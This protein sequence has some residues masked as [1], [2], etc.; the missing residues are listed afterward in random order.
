[1]Q[2]PAWQTVP[3]VQSVVVVQVS[4]QR[5]PVCPGP[6]SGARSLSTLHA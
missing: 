3:L 1:M 4:T 6:F 5:L 2:M